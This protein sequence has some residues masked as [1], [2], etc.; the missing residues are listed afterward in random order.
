MVRALLLII[1]VSGCFYGCKKEE[2]ADLLLSNVNVI[3]VMQGRVIASRDLLIVGDQIKK[4][5]PHGQGNISS[6]KIVDGTGKYVMPGF[7]D[8]HVHFRTR[9]LE[10]DSLIHQLSEENR[11]LLPIYVAYGITSVYDMGTNI[12]DSLRQ[13]RNQ[14]HSGTLVGPN[15]YITGPKIEGSDAIFAGSLK[16]EDQEDV[17]KVMAHLSEMS[18]D[19]IKIMGAYDLEPK[20]YYEILRLAKKLELRSF[21]HDLETLSAE[22]SSN[23][24][25]DALAHLRGIIHECFKEFDSVVATMKAQEILTPFHP[26]YDAYV[27][28][29]ISKMDTSILRSKLDKMSL[30]NTALVSTVYYDAYRTKPSTYEATFL[31]P[32]KYVGP[33]FRRDVKARYERFGNATTKQM[34]FVKRV[35]E[36]NR[37]VLKMLPSTDM[38]LLIGTDSGYGNRAP[39]IGYFRELKELAD[40]GLSNAYIIRA[41]TWNAAQFVGKSNFEGTVDKGK[42]ADLVLLDKNPL[43][44]LPSEKT[45]CGVIRNGKWF[46]KN[47][48]EDILESLEEK[49]SEK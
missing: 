27:D 47:N 14:I 2:T 26:E 39:G 40:N 49:Y 4:I 15:I 44:L 7:W 5:I 12:A 23:Q 30:N 45:L 1:I 37:K 32:L 6:I 13:W 21:S 33:F 22:E 38:K 25:L 16:I 34:N 17:K 48:L 31:E 18:V 3:D 8:M 29:M 36:G 35:H 11:D 9:K 41:A 20:S 43:D 10:W 19:G 24:G 28:Q 46:D 42:K